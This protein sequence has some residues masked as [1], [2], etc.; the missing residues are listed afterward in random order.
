MSPKPTCNDGD[1]PSTTITP[2]LLQGVLGGQGRRTLMPSALG[3]GRR[4]RL[5][6]SDILV[7][8]EAAIALVDSTEEDEPS[9]VLHWN[10]CEQWWGR[11]PV[12]FYF[13]L[14]RKTQPPHGRGDPG[15]QG[16]YHRHSL[17]Y[18]QVKCG[19]IY[20]HTRGGNTGEHWQRDKSRFIHSFIHH[21]MYIDNTKCKLHTS[22]QRSDAP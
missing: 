13:E 5:R 9:T 3:G 12:L 20:V 7:I 6:S 15:Q 21:N 1:I 18:K 8:L 2:L 14:R 16:E 4:A 22:S 17:F 10:R 19:H 11:S